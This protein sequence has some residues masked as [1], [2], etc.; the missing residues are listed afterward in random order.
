MEAN[1][2]TLP[3]PRCTLGYVIHQDVSYYHAERHH[4]GLDHQLLEPE[5][6]RGS[7]S[8][9]VRRRERLGG[10]LRYYDRD[11]A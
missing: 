6:R 2:D 4:P 7:D 9:Q 3:Y 8:G 10:L 11:A 5:P 1:E